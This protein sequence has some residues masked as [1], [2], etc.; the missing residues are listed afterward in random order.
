L[1]KF[2]FKKSLGQ[3]FLVD[4]GVIDLIIDFAQIEKGDHVLEVG[5]GEGALIEGLVNSSKT[6][7]AI[8]K[9]H[10]LIPILRSNFSAVKII[11]GDALKYEFD[12][13]DE[14]V[15][16]VSNVPYSISTDF[17]FWL[18]K[19]R[20][21]IKRASLLL[22]KEYAERIAAEPGTRAFGS[23]SVFCQLYAN[24]ELGEVIKPE[25]FEPQPKVDSQLI[26][27]DFEKELVVED[28]AGFE[29]FVRACFFTKRKTIANSLVHSSILEK[30]QI[31]KIFDEVG[32]DS[33]I[34][35]EQLSIG[36]FVQLF[37]VYRSFIVK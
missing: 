30:P 17:I 27:L 19:N 4:Q 29:K 24:M 12:D 15:V 5:P 26:S 3:N 21:K 2:D 10:R 32:I 20:D 22:Q 23:L 35:A 9:D 36:D 33:K 16:V 18:I 8:E 11:E 28:V 37:D 1:K 14:K 13:Y 25:A 7:R 31:Q 34:R 6:Y